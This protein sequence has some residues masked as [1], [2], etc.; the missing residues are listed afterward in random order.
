MRDWVPRRRHCQS[1]VW[2]GPLKAR[3]RWGLPAR[4]GEVAVGSRGSLKSAISS[5]QSL[6]QREL[7][8]SESLLGKRASHADRHAKERGHQD[9]V[10]PNQMSGRYRPRDG[11]PMVRRRYFG[12]TTFPSL[13]WPPSYAANHAT[14]APTNAAAPAIKARIT[15]ERRALRMPSRACD[16]CDIGAT[17][18]LWRLQSRVSGGQPDQIGTVIRSNAGVA[19]RGQQD[20]RRLRLARNPNQCSADAARR[21]RAGPDRMR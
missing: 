9:R 13:C 20:A 6:M 16:D 2:A 10:A 17:L 14:A 18:C 11:A 15:A 8:I 7:I 3:H 1:H 12:T 4:S 5:L 19:C 21:G